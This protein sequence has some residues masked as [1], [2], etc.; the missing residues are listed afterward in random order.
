MRKRGASLRNVARK[1]GIANST[2]SY[3]FKDIALS[4]RY[5]NQLKK[6]ADRS[7]I[8]A[9]KAAVQWHNFQKEKRLEAAKSDARKCLAAI[10]LASDP[11]AELSLALLY[12]GEGM[13]KTNSTAMGNSHPLIL[14]FFVS[15]LE[16]LYAVPRSEMKCEIH[17]RADQDPL[18]ISRYWSRILRIPL[19]NFG[20]PSV[21]LRTAGRP[22]YPDYRGV[23]VVRCA[24]VAIQR[25]LM[26]I[27]TEFCVKAAEQRAVSSV[28]RAQH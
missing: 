13:K 4:Q 9:R 11:I 17:V 5:K 16:R 20:K 25:K 10:D 6:R 24:R 2:L 8:S 12:L 26:Y 27:A 23:C 15:M 18:V 28:G 21:D 22:T 1:L 19:R 3:W 7:L 14:S